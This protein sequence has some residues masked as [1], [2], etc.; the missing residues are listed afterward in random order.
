MPGYNHYPDCTCGWC[1]GGGGAIGTAHLL[2][3]FS[4][5]HRDEDFCRPTTCRYCGASVYFVRHNGG[6]V[7]FDELGPPWPKHECFEDDRY[8]IQLRRLLTTSSQVFGIIIETDTTRPGEGGRIVVRCSD[9]AIIDSEFDTKA[10]LSALPG[11]L[12]VVVHKEQGELSLRFV[13]PAQLKPYRYWRIILGVV[14]CDWRIMGE[15]GRRIENERT[16][17][18]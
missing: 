9:G 10:D 3:R 7:W 12:V 1:R 8:G 16:A 18:T 14:S 2:G 6:S 15:L 13:Y 5:R 4:W 17:I 11:Q